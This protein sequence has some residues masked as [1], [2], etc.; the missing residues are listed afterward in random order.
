MRNVLAIAQKELRAYFVSPIAYVAIGIFAVL[1]G[2]FYVASL[3]ILL[4]VSMQ[5][6]MFG[7]GG[8]QTININEF[9]VR[10]LL[11]NTAVILLL[12]LPF[13]TARAYAEEKRSGTIELLMTSPLTDLQ[14]LLGKF[15]G[16]LTLFAVMLGVTAIHMGVL[17]WYGE[18]ELGP[19]L[20]GYLGLG[21][22][23]ASFISVGL[24]VSSA[25]RNQIVA[26]VITFGVLLLFWV[27]SWMADST[28]PTTRSVLNY[29]SILE[30]FDDFSKGI[31]DTKHVVYYLSFITF[32]LFLTAKSVDSERWRG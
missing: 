25:T 30:H 7:A 9:M 14:I 16:A 19:I 13:L 27:I 21:L 22:M 8:P 28:G 31:I 10:P 6:G 4:Q 3:S 23:G 11:S 18:P 1:F 5:S 29:L 24:L 26:G 20:T 12:F 2:Y 17:F 32:G 15:L